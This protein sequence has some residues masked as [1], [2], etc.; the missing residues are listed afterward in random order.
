MLCLKQLNILKEVFHLESTFFIQKKTKVKNH[1]VIKKFQPLFNL[2]RAF[3]N[4]LQFTQEK[5]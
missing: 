3:F 5:V 1:L 4:G 2:S